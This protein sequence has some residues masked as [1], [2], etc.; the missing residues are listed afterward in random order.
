HIGLDA[1]LEFFR[2]TLEARVPGKMTVQTAGKLFKTREPLG[3]L[4]A[5]GDAADGSAAGAAGSQTGL[6]QFVLDLWQRFFLQPM[7]LHASSGRQVNSTLS[8]ARGDRCNRAGLTGGDNPCRQF[9]PLHV[10]SFLALLIDA[11]KAIFGADGAH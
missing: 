5:A 2:Q 3:A 11:V 8:E 7:D 4:T 9:D 10:E 1:Y 6:G